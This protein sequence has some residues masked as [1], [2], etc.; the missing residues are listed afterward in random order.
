MVD[1]LE[2]NF[3]LMKAKGEG[4]VSCMNPSQWSGRLRS[5]ALV[6]YQADS[7]PKDGHL[8]LVRH[9]GVVAWVADNKPKTQV[10]N[11]N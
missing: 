3:G 5:V 2:D 9:A 6:G 11:V 1:G 4:G 8:A 10:W 7:G